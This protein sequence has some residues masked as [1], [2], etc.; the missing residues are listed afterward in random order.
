MMKIEREKLTCCSR[1]T[2]CSEA[3]CESQHPLL[4]KSDNHEFGRTSV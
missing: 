3:G 2:I 4:D 1:Q